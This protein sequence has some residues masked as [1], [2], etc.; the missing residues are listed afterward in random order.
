MN[1]TRAQ[2]GDEGKKT[3]L[4]GRLYNVLGPRAPSVIMFGALLCTLAV[5]LFHAYRVSLVG[6]YLAWVL[7]DIV[8]LLGIEL[9]LALVC[10][11]RPRRA[12]IRLATLLAMLVCAWSIMNA[13]WIIRT[14]TQV[15]PTVFL[16]LFRDP[17]SALGMVVVGLVQ[18]PLA[19][20]LLLGPSGVAFTFFVWFLVKPLPPHYN[21]DR[22]AK[23]IVFSLVII[24]G[25]VML[26][27]LLAFKRK[28]GQVILA[29]LRYNCQIRAVT[30]LIVADPGR[31]A[32]ESLANAQRKMPLCGELKLSPASDRQQANHNVVI[33]VLEGVQYVQTSLYDTIAD[34]TPYL[35]SLAKSGVKFTGM[36]TSL[37][38]TTKALFSLLTGSWPSA[39]QDIAEAVPVEKPYA[40]LA[41][42]LKN[43]LNFRTAFFQSA[44]G[45][46]ECRPGLVANLG[47]D[48]F[49]ARDDLN[50]PSKYLGYLGSD[51]FAMI[52]PIVKWINAEKV[53]FLLT[54][55]CSATHD[56]YVVPEW[57]GTPARGLMGRYRQSISYTDSFIAA[58]DAALSSLKLR[59]RTIFCVIGDHGEA[60]GE[61]GLQGHERIVFDETL[62]VP[63]VMR[64]PGLIEPETAIDD[65]VSSVDL[66][67]TLLAL[68][69][70]EAS[71]AGF[72]G[73]DA[74]GPLPE[75]RRVYFSCWN[76]QGQAGFLWENHKFAYD[77]T[78]EM[79][80]VYDLRTDPYELSAI[81]MAE[82]ES[83][84]TID[85]IVEWRKATLFQLP[86]AQR[87]KELLFG[88][89]TCW[90][91][92]RIAWT[93]YTQP[94]DITPVIK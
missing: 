66:A 20:A 39:S 6:E 68:L 55:L 69:G 59:D 9:V 1:R 4:I 30:S 21:R 40:S 89:W 34:P 47:F 74:L 29:G 18:M 63:W 43:Q 76:Q 48:T 32:R 41:S 22:F 51:E 70:F 7:A 56:P 45:S 60:F 54:V 94:A 65:P 15:L 86:Q 78:A 53:P 37:P 58:L 46:F 77:P 88:H 8:A 71:D 92:K 80:S 72:D 57:F 17:L 19:T 2:S 44:K 33:V 3:S 64:A 26:N 27:G 67:P 90:W 5:K 23:R 85:E 81:D 49:W 16:P 52:G 82:A 13:G 91:N 42:A 10:F 36:R 28:P 24:V 75:G 84:K 11:W 38:H 83:Q 25:A 31:L 12:I 61:H 50:D 73:A 35:A 79:L 62:R 87:G 14:G 93:K